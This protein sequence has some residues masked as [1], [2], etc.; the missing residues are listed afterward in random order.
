[1]ATKTSQF[2]ALGQDDVLWRKLYLRNQKE[3]IRKRL[4]AIKL[5]WEGKS[6]T[7]VTVL[8]PVGYNT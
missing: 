6:R 4:K 7:E 1:M 3:Y 8:L 5:L 2:L